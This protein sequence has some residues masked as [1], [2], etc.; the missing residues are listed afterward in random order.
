MVEG[1]GTRV[2]RGKLLPVA[3]L[4]HELLFIKKKVLLE[5]SHTYHLHMTSG[6]F[7]TLKAE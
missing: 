5:Q 7:P 4:V 6:S 3:K 1:G 2:G